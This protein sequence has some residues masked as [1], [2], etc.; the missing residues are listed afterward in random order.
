MCFFEPTWPFYLKHN[1]P[2]NIYF[3]KRTWF[4]YVLSK[5]Q[6]MFKILQ[7]NAVL[8]KTPTLEI[9]RSSLRNS[10]FIGNE[11]RKKLYPIQKEA[12]KQWK[13]VVLVRDKLFIDGM[14]YYQDEND[15]ENTNATSTKKYGYRDSL[16]TTPK[17]ANR[18][19]KH[20]RP[21]DT[22]HPPRYWMIVIIISTA[23]ENN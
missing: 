7:W 11:R 3:L 8:R 21:S 2:K 19:Y 14:L 9:A 17:E 5:Y 12:R 4:L 10:I 16:L 13:H 1:L 23:M 15:N 22:P 6:G 18:P 20:P